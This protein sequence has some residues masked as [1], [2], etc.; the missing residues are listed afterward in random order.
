MINL[1]HK[2]LLSPWDITIYTLSIDTT[3]EQLLHSNPIKRYFPFQISTNLWRQ[4]KREKV[5]VKR[6]EIRDKSEK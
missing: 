6:E 3:P 4:G 1:W 2:L 5:K